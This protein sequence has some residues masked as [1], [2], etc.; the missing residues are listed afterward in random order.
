MILLIQPI[1][2]DHILTF[3]FK[4]FKLDSSNVSAMGAGGGYG[5]ETLQ[6]ATS[7]FK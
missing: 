7:P 6:R 2:I 4:E 5:N 1:I 3:F